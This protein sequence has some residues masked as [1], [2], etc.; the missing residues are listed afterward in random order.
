M[1]ICQQVVQSLSLTTACAPYIRPFLLNLESG[2]LWGEDFQQKN[3][4]S[5]ADGSRQAA[6]QSS[7]SIAPSSKHLWKHREASGNGSVAGTSPS[8]TIDSQDIAMLPMPSVGQPFK[9][10]S[11]AEWDNRCE[12][13][14]AG[15]PGEVTT[16]P[17]TVDTRRGE[18]E[19]Y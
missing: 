14:P 16:V 10:Q 1:V 13:I 15:L 17:V 19:G 7:K 6:T 2:F 3:V 4:Q 12:A 8:R 9:G 5:Y 11:S 18:L